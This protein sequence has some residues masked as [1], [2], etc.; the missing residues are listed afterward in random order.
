MY[1][2]Q[3]RITR[4]RQTIEVIVAAKP[5]HAG[6]DPRALLVDLRPRDNFTPLR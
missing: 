6:I 1:L 2:G 3:H 4:S 5:G